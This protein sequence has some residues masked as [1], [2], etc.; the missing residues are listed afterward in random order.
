MEHHCHRRHAWMGD[1]L[2]ILR[3]LT[4]DK[5]SSSGQAEE[6]SAERIGT[7]SCGRHFAGRVGLDAALKTGREVGARKRERPT[8]RGR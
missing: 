5:A 1:H 3:I 7:G 6:L 8:S 2:L 4:P